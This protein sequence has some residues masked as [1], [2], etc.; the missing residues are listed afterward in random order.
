MGLV[1]LDIVGGAEILHRGG[2][3]LV[4]NLHQ[5]GKELRGGQVV[6]EGGV[7]R[8]HVAVAHGGVAGGQHVVLNLRHRALEVGDDVQPLGAHPAG[9][10][11]GGAGMDIAGSDHHGELAVVGGP[12][13]AGG[14]GIGPHG[15]GA[16]PAKGHAAG[17]HPHLVGG[18]A[19][20]GDAALAGVGGG[21]PAAGGGAVHNGEPH[22]RFAGVGN[23]GQVEVV[24]HADD[25]LVG[26]GKAHGLRGGDSHRAGGG[27]ARAVGEGQ[28]GGAGAGAVDDGALGVAAIGHGVAHIGHA[29]VAAGPLHGG[30]VGG[31]RAVQPGALV[32]GEGQAVGADGGPCGNASATAA[33]VDLHVIRVDVAL[34]A[35]GGF[36]AQPAVALNGGDGQPHAGGQRGDGLVVGAGARTQAQAGLGGDAHRLAHLKAIGVRVGLGLWV[37]GVRGA[38]DVLYKFPADVAGAAAA[39][40]HPQPAVALHRGDGQQSAGGKHRHHRGGDAGA[41]AQIQ[42]IGCGDPHGA[43]R[44]D[45]AAHRVG[46]LGDMFI[47]PVTAGHVHKLRGNSVGGKAGAGALQGFVQNGCHLAALDALVRPEGAVGKAADPILGHGLVDKALGPVAGHVGKA[48]AAGGEAVK[49][50]AHGGDELRPGDGVVGPEG[51]IFIAA[52]DVQLHQGVHRGGVPGAGADVGEAAACHRRVRGQQVVEHLGHLGAGHGPVGIE[53]CALFTGHVRFVAAHHQQGVGGEGLLLAVLHGDAALLPGALVLRNLRGGL[54]LAGRGLLAGG[55]LLGA[56][57]FPGLAL[58]PGGLGALRRGAFLRR[59]GGALLPGAFPLWGLAGSAGGAFKGGLRRQGAGCR[60]GEQQRQ[61]QRRNPSGSLFSH[62]K[63][64]IHCKGSCPGL[65]NTRHHYTGK[66]T[67]LQPFAPRIHNLP[68]NA[69]KKGRQVLA[70]SLC[71]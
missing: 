65:Q 63:P 21:V 58:L 44:L 15:V 24:P 4:G 53:A 3:G 6:V 40:A 32:L 20:A 35:A 19:I 43:A 27:G 52:E 47:G 46:G 22:A 51:A 12:A 61:Q 5:L 33:G 7:H 56:L 11:G 17:E 23:G 2:V 16:R 9:L 25:V 60:Q 36:H 30:E 26:I 55:L 48:R 13:A 31:D 34:H 49:A 57:P 38:G 69:N 28:G 41:G 8:H 50:L 42:P 10:G 68:Q 14:L 64:P 67:N 62:G 18:Q 45:G 70:G 54:L 1:H 29:G 39:G 66:I 59:L 37:G 71:F